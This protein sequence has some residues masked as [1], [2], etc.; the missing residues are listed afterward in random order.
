MFSINV[1]ETVT[2]IEKEKR[3]KKKKFLQIT[4]RRV[5]NTMY[6]LG[7]WISARHID[8]NS[9]GYTQIASANAAAGCWLLILN[10]F[11]AVFAINA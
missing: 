1:R 9:I 4:D 3:E 6:R 2:S 10:S 7:D 8:P 5:N 11:Q